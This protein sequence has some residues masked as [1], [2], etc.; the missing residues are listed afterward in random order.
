MRTAPSRA[1]E[2]RGEAAAPRPSP[3]LLARIDRLARR[4][5]AFHRLAHHPLCSRY[6]AEV[7]RAGRRWRVC[8]GCALTGAGA[9]AGGV[10]GTVLPPPGALGLGALAALLAGG[11]AWAVSIRSGR[12]RSKL[13]ARLAPM[14]LAAALLALGLRSGGAAGIV[15]ALAAAG[16]VAAAALAYRR[17]GPDRQPCAGCPEAPA[18]ASC[19]GFR[20]IARRER[21]FS[22]L[23]GRW[24][25][26]DLFTTRQ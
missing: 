10:A 5:H 26:R 23:T 18:S 19:S 1:S 17:R 2:A 24:I 3:A 22:R 8:R 12:R 20:A 16:S 4:A 14:A 21:A 13:L 9:L 11:A 15:A 7:M 6:A 25:E